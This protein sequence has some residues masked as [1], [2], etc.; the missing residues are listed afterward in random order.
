M[1]GSALG[2]WWFEPVARGRIAALRLLAYAFV[3]V[4][5]LVTTPWVAS[6]AR[7]PEVL[8]EPLRIDR[9]LL[10][11]VTGSRIEVLRLA[12]L[13]AAALALT[14]R[15]PRL[16]GAT[17]GVL[18]L[19]WMLVGF[20]YGKVDHDRVGFLVLLAVLATLGR[21][22]A[23]DRTPDEAA[24]WA[25]RCVQVA[26]VLTY[27]LAAFAKLRFGGLAWLDSATLLRAV[28]R[29]GTELG[30]L[31]AARPW[32]LHLTQYV[33]LIGELL[34]PLLLFVRGRVRTVALAVAFGFH[35]AVFATVTIIF[36][37]HLVAMTS[38]LPLERA[39]RREATPPATPGTAAAP[40]TSSPARPLLSR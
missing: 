40:R 29:R 19:E 2:R 15:A 31:L 38:F 21:V 9:L 28:L 3:F 18:Y 5:V 11:S 12:L 35:L 10:P 37:P 17:V 16:L 27:F 13:A 26:C 23:G 32:T 39:W 33:V 8:Y 34:S 24:G 7:T 20:S 6:H 25:V 1:S 14:G 22:R 36:L 30:D 4:D